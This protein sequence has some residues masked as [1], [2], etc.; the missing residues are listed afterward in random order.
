MAYE[1]DIKQDRDLEEGILSCLLSNKSSLEDEN[2]KKLSESDFLFQYN[3][4][5]F[6]AIVD[7]NSAG[8][9]VDVLSLTTILKDRKQLEQIDVIGIRKYKK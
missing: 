3:R 6:Q 9:P 5:V 4:V 7:L 1:L 8:V 2:V